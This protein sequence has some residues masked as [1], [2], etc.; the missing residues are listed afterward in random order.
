M[1]GYRDRS[2]RCVLPS[3]VDRV[4]NAFDKEKDTM[5]KGTRG[6]QLGCGLQQGRGIGDGAQS[7]GSSH[8]VKKY[9]GPQD[10]RGACIHMWDC[11]AL[12]TRILERI[13]VDFFSPLVSIHSKRTKVALT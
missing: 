5:V 9:S 7:T 12:V 2:M 4:F 10:L 6:F 1:W 11:P 8:Y 13:T 3:R